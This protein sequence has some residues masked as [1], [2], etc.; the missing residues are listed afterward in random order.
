MTLLFDPPRTFQ[1]PFSKGGDLYFKFVFKP[2]V[3]D[4]DGNPVLDGAGHRQYAVADYPPGS[5][6]KLAI[7]TDEPVVVD[8]T[9]EGSV[10]TFWGDFLM[11]DTVP[12]GKFWRAVIT[13]EDG[14]DQVLC[15]GTTVRYD[16]KA[17]Q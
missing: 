15:N 8:A 4:E 17:S 1:L 7:D 11:A 16:G 12:K 13:F 14:L 2:L 9:I 3:V 10:A 5:T 6:V